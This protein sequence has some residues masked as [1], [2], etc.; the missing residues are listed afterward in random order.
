MHETAQPTNVGSND[1]L[2]LR[3]WLVEREENALR[4]ASGVMEQEKAG[5]FEDAAY[6]RQAYT[7]IDERAKMLETTRM[8]NGMFTRNCIAMQAA[9]IDRA[10]RGEKEGWAWILNTLD[11]PGLLPDLDAAKAAGGAQAWFDA[12][13]AAEEARVAALQA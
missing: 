11:G 4:I 10:L 13:L 6:F 9:L 7:A 1:Q 8:L 2:G 3:E 5:W 12:E